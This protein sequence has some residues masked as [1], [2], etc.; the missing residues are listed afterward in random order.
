MGR[1]IPSFRIALEE[2]ITSWGPFRAS[3]G[4]SSRR[5]L[6]KLFNQARGYCSAA[7]NAT[8]PVRFEAMLMAVIFS[9]EKRL[10]TLARDIEKARLEIDAR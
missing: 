3:T 5:T 6:D 9:H 2:E 10:E 7:S 4:A 1:T 8:R